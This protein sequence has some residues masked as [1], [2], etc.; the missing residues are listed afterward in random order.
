V[1]DQSTHLKVQGASIAS[2]HV[3]VHVIRRQNVTHSHHSPL[4]LYHCLAVLDQFIK[5]ISIENL[6]A[7]FQLPFV[8]NEELLNA[9]VQN[10]EL[11]A[12]ILVVSLLAAVPV[13]NLALWGCLL[14]VAPNKCNAIA[15]GLLVALVS[16]WHLLIVEELHYLN[17]G[18]GEITAS[19][20]HLV[21]KV[22]LQLVVS[23]AV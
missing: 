4:G 23:G 1:P 22:G 18:L 12:L 19:L 10:L 8:I 11:W 6:D 9:D 15:I 7:Q 14:S 17:N 16:C 2:K 21:C 20:R 5:F 3:D 13:L